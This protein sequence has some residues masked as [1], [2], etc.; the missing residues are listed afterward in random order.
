MRVC[1][2]HCSYKFLVYVLKREC[3]DLSFILVI[4]VMLGLNARNK[5]L[6]FCDKVLLYVQQL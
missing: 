6:L 4:N 3:F 5:F 1:T 2:M